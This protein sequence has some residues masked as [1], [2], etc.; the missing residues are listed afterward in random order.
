MEGFSKIVFQVRAECPYDQHQVMLHCPL[1]HIDLAGYFFGRPVFEAVKAEYLLGLFGEL[2]QPVF[3]IVHKLCHIQVII[4]PAICIGR[5]KLG[6]AAYILFMN[7]RRSEV[8]NARI[9]YAGN[10]VSFQVIDPER[11]TAFP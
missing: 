8:V 10:Q 11:C 5:F 7:H 2:P 1:G 9:L 6:V 3:Y 4:S